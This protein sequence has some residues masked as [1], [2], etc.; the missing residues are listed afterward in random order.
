M[1]MIRCDVPTQYLNIGMHCEVIVNS[2][3]RPSRRRDHAYLPRGLKKSGAE[4]CYFPTDN[5]KFLTEEI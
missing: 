1:L 2:D 3:R 4:I 5:C